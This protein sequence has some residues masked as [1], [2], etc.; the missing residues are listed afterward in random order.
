MF[1]DIYN[2]QISVDIYFL[3]YI[4]DHIFEN[5]ILNARVVINIDSRDILTRTVIIG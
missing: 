3:L 4:A 1:T 2:R 5:C